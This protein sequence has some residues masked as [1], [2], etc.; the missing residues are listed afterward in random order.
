MSSVTYK[1][2]FFAN[3]KLEI[4]ETIKKKIST[5]VD[6]ESDNPLR[7]VNYETVVTDCNDTKHNYQVQVTARI[8]D[9]NQ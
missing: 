8:K 1:F 7:Y 4:Q 9:D 5:Y 6:N 3:N 2:D